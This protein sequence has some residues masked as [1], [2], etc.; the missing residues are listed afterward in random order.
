MQT[1]SYMQRSGNDDRSWLIHLGVSFL[2]L[3]LYEPFTTIY[4]YLPPFLALAF[5]KIY[6]SKKSLERWLWAIYIYIFEIDHALPVLSLFVIFF[7]IY[8]ILHFISKFILCHI[9]QKVLATSL[10]Y[11]AI[12][13]MLHFM[14]TPLHLYDAMFPNIIVYYYLVDL[15][16]VVLYED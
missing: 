13:L 5:W 14:H 2:F 8:F 4:V 15:I 11:G 16:L 12:F 3:L 10:L 1:F 9:C 6:S 7:T